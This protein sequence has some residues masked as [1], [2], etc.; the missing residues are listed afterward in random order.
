MRAEYKT[1]Q[2]TSS[3]PTVWK[4]TETTIAPEQEADMTDEQ[5]VCMAVDSIVKGEMAAAQAADPSLAGSIRSLQVATDA[6][7]T[8][9]TKLKGCL[10][11]TVYCTSKM[12]GADGHAYWSYPNVC[13]AE[14]AGQHMP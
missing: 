6:V 1:R 5:V 7:T 13:R 3:E 2:S 4:A 14:K 11:P 9:E 8:G 10:W 12:T